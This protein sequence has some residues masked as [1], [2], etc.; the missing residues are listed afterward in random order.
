VLDFG[1]AKALADEGAAGDVAANSPTLAASALTRGGMLLGTAAYMSPE[2]AR[3]K[4]V[5]KRS[6][7]FAFGS[8]LLFDVRGRGGYDVSPDGK[9]FLVVKLP[10]RK[11][12]PAASSSSSSSWNGSTRSAAESPLAR[13][14]R[15]PGL[16]GKLDPKDFGDPIP[17]DRDV[18]RCHAP[19]F[20]PIDT[21]RCEPINDSALCPCVNSA[22]ASAAARMSSRKSRSRRIDDPGVGE[23]LF[24][25]SA[26]Q[27]S[28]RDQIDLAAKKG[29]EFPL[30]REVM[31]WDDH[32]PPHFHVYYGGKMARMEINTLKLVDGS[33]PR[34]ALRL[35]TEWA[36]RHRSELKE[37]WER[38][39]RHA[40]LNKIRPL[41]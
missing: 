9:R 22:M 17:Q 23:H 30:G 18:S 29:G 41:D 1:L 14:S 26:S 40:R 37:N 8:V 28:L 24:A 25:Q 34:T 15:L 12:L 5:D 4:K 16:V 35:A 2:Q 38:A 39:Q 31:F 21:R 10:R 7:I 27:R 13:R 11:L 36:R 6:D 20:G 3:G 32:V 33:L 19:H